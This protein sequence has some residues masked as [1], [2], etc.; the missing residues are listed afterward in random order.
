MAALGTILV[1]VL[2][3]LFNLSMIG[4]FV[5]DI[6]VDSISK[7]HVGNGCNMPDV[8]TFAHRGDTSVG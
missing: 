5:F 3:T 7:N 1:I 2:V 6:V 4:L 8:L